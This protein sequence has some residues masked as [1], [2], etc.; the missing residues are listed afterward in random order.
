MSETLKISDIVQFR[1]KDYTEAKAL[2]KE[3]DGMVHE[4]ASLID[5]T[6]LDSL[7]NLKRKFNSKMVHL[8]VYYSKVSCYKEN[9]EYLNGQRKRIKA[10]SIQHLIDNT[11]TKVSYSAAENLVYGYPYYIERVQLLER[12]KQFFYLLDLQYKNYQNTQTS[13]YQTV[14][15][16]SKEKQSTLNSN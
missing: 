9:Y 4:Y 16:F 6:D 12:L 11:E 5:S 2:I 13:L 1:E 15:L 14:S 7:E 10:E 3:M 8:A